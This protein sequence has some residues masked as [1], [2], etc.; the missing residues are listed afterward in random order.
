M[1]GNAWFRKPRHCWHGLYHVPPDFR[2]W[3]DRPWR[4]YLVEHIES[5]QCGLFGGRYNLRFHFG[6]SYRVCHE[7]FSIDNSLA[8]LLLMFMKSQVVKLLCILYIQVSQLLIWELSSLLSLLLPMLFLCC[9]SCIHLLFNCHFLYLSI[10]HYPWRAAICF[11][12]CRSK[13]PSEQKQK[14]VSH[15]GSRCKMAPMTITRLEN[16]LF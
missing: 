15:P 14:P 3:D 13:R 6:Q 4:K 7:G 8:C 9:S 12:I 16:M 11:L 5:R 10:A 2:R 1:K